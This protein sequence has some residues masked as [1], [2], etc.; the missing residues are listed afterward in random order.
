[1]K[2]LLYFLKRVYYLTLSAE[3]HEEIVW[4]RLKKLFS[5]KD[6][7]HGVYEKEK[8]V[9]TVVG[10]GEGFSETFYYLV[11][12]RRFH[13][14]VSVL[15]DYPIDLTSELF[16]L[17]AHFNNLLGSG[18]VKVDVKNSSVE[19]QLKQHLIVPVLFSSE[20]HQLLISHHEISKDVFKAFRRLV[21]EQE[22]PAI[23]IADLMK[24]YDNNNEGEQ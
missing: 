19:Y 13:C 1:M 8:Y 20:I 21:I 12:D 2:K 5:D 6:W 23:I 17:A 3:K 15:R 24:E 7:N 11:Y 4:K 10:I 14:Q 9:E 16:I 18:V 22:A